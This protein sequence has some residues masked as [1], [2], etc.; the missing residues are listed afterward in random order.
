MSNTKAKILSVSRDLFNEKGFSNVTIRMI[1]LKLNMS[2]G[3]LNYHFKKREDIL[4]TLYFEMVENFDNRVKEL[5]TRE[6]SLQTIKEDV[7][8]SLNRM[9]ENRFFWTDLYYLVRL[10]E[11]IR[12][13]FLN[14][15]RKRFNGYKYLFE[16]LKGKG[17]LRNFEFEK[18]SDFLIER[19]LGY[20]NTWLYNS[21]I[22]EVQINKDYI[23]SIS[24]NL[25]GMLYPYLTDLGRS[26]YN[27]LFPDFSE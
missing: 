13:H 16:D 9:F 17:V 15:Y 22:Y 26:Q 7:V 18:E 6:I 5:G 19:M 21:F 4:E 2:S 3:N 12:N 27:I 11:K 8:E 1:A 25:L 14:V 24:E 20:S 23:E 10:N